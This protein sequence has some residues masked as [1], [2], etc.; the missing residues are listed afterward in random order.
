MTGIT[1]YSEVCVLAE[2]LYKNITGYNFR[3]NFSDEKIYE[4]ILENSTSCHQTE[5][6]GEGTPI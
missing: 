4:L 1:K 2:A 6:I 3:K 5:N